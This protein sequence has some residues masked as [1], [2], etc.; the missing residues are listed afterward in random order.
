MT[1]NSIAIVTGSSRGIGRQTA[2]M[3]SEQGYKVG[4]NFIQDRVSAQSLINDIDCCGGQ[5]FLLPGDMSDEKTICDVFEQADKH[6]LLRVLV[7][8][9]G[10]VAQQSS[11]LGMD[12]QRIHKIIDT[13]LIGPMLCCQ[14]AVK[15]M[16]EQNPKD[17]RCIINISS[18]A[19]KTGSPNEY[20]DYAASKGGLDSFTIGLAKEV[21]KYGIRVNGVRP[22]TVD[23]DIHRL[24]GEPER[25]KSIAKII[26]MQRPGTAHE[27]GKTVA[28][29]ASDEASYMTGTIIDVAGGL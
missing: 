23:T 15:R 24:G 3:L 25:A 20:V 10:I 21:A 16:M 9:V 8:N 19:S 17:K 29:L 26:P 22:G 6:G 2:L 14:Q 13:N 1:P 27:V 18:I 12:S 28:W 11:L 7:N 5:G 4:V